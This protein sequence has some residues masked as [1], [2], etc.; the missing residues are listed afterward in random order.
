MNLRFT[1]VKASSRFGDMIIP[2]NNCQP[3][4]GKRDLDGS[5]EICVL[6]GLSKDNESE[7]GDPATAAFYFTWHYGF[8]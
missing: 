6:T 5:T 2:W 4:V 3:D 1:K 8:H 7:I